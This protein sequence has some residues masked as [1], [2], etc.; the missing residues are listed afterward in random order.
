MAPQ[1]NWKRFSLRIGGSVLVVALLFFF[2]PRDQLFAAL[3]RFSAGIWL[4][5]VSIYLCLHLIG[6]AKWRML[7]NAAGAGIGFA[8]AA[9]C[10]YYGLFGNT[11]LP[12]VI[13]G[14][15]VRAGLA[16]K[17][18]RA[19]GA[20]L[21]GSIADRAVDSAGL[22]LLAG[23]GALFLPMALDEDS[24][25]IFWG[26]AALV[27][28]ACVAMGVLFFALPARRFPFRA[29]RRLVKARFAVRSL[30]KHPAR[31]FLALGLALVQQTANVIMNLWLGRLA[32]IQNATFLMWLFVWPLAKLAATVP[33]TQGGIGVREAAQGMLFL[34]LGVSIEKAVAT[35]LIFQAIVIG[36]NLLAG[37]LAAT[38]GRF[39]SPIH[40]GTDSAAQ[41]SA[42]RRGIAS[43]FFAGGLMFFAANT[44]AIAHGTGFAGAAWVNWMTPVPGLDASFAGSLA[45][46]LYGAV[47][48]YPLGRLLGKLTGD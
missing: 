17:I 19:R 16:M 7:I 44:L 3:S 2:L 31:F 43:A 29:R 9:R 38:L 5:G 10:Y 35:G 15:I 34:P 12:S 20:V 28:T 4:A 46:F 11:F 6:V 48:G 45:G 33:L 37:G 24:T 32:L 36:G 14:D 42:H 26:L 40:S 8:H 1:R 21:M 23:T 41:K 30:M 13:G 22:A 27:L 39:A 47:T 18:S 25:S